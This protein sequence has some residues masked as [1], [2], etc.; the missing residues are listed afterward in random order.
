M[1]SKE[2]SNNLLSYIIASHRIASHLVERRK[3]MRLE[4][5]VEK[6]NMKDRLERKQYN[7]FLNLRYIYI[8]FIHTMY[9]VK[10]NDIEQ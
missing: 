10:E 1:C 8:Y 5:H 4:E 7:A 2:I 6:T 3:V 9:V